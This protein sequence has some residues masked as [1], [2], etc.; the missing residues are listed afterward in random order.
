LRVGEEAVTETP[1]FQ[2]HD[3]DVLPVHLVSRGDE[4]SSIQPEQMFRVRLS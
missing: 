4:R 1:H 3:C 2:N